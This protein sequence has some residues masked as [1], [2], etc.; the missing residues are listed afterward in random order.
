MDTILHSNRFFDVV[1]YNQI[2][3]VK[4]PN[5]V[6][7]LPISK[8]GKVL[9]IKQYRTI[10]NKYTWEIPGGIIEKEENPEAAVI[11]E[12]R[13]ETGYVAEQITHVCVKDTSNGTTNEKL[14]FFEASNIYK[15]SD[16]FEKNIESDFF[17]VQKCTEMIND[18]TID[19]LSSSFAILHYYLKQFKS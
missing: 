1:E 3:Y 18:G 8:D 16:P 13:E 7:I 5:A 12:L 17:T 10:M 2:I 11:R 15:C 14:F 4:R 6:L 9:L 19:C